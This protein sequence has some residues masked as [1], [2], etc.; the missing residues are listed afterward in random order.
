[1]DRKSALLN[2]LRINRDPDSPQRALRRWP[3]AIGFVFTLLTGGAIGWWMSSDRQSPEIAVAAPAA[4]PQPLAAPNPPAAS[5]DASGYVVARRQATVSAQITGRVVQMLI[6]EGQT[7]SEGDVIARLDDSTARAALVRAQAELALAKAELE[8]ARVALA[9]ATPIFR[10]NE[11]QFAAHVISAHELD[12][13]RA[14]YHAVETVFVVKERAVEVAEAAE[15][16]A[17]RQLEN[18]LVR[19]PFDGVI[20]VKAAQAG[21]IVSP[22]SAGG[23]FT[24]T[25]IGTIVDMD[26]LE[27]EV[28]VSESFINRVETG[29][30]ASIRLNA[31]P[32]TD[33]EGEVIAVV[34]TADRARATVKVRVG[35]RH[36]DARLLP[37][38]GARVSF[39]RAGGSSVAVVGLA[40]EERS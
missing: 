39:R 24:R 9:D 6:E 17:E 10:R 22:S 21:E 2:D 14:S 3:H 23:G 27:V 36:R 5:L 18:T 38:M 19:A 20:T 4:V 11:L 31:Y 33:F 25:G 16:V 30:E 1:M 35:F 7:V 13:A 29:Q 28:D 26:S 8:A 15:A 12:T 34:P 40:L 32:E 37:E